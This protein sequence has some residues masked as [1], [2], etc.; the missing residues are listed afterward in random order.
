MKILL[1]YR[2]FPMALG[3]YFDW[4]LKDLGHQVFT[5]GCYNGGKIPWGPEFDFPDYDSPPDLEIPE[6]GSFP[7]E[8]V[9]NRMPWYP[10]M[11]LQAADTT[12]L[13]GKPLCPNVILATDPHSI[14]YLSR[15][16]DASHFACMQ[17]YYMDRYSFKNKFWVPYAYMPGIHKR[18]PR[19]EK[20]YD[21]VF[22]GLQ[23]EHRVQALKE[24]ERRGL[25]VFNTLGILFDEYNKTYNKGKIAFNWSSLE[26]LPAR[27][28]EGLAMGNCVL[29]NNQAELSSIEHIIP[30]DCYA[31]F[32]ENRGIYGGVA[33]KA[34]SLVST[35]IWKEIADRGWK[36]VTTGKNTYQDRCNLILEEVFK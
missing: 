34:V 15:L 28:W 32:N 35:D 11:V 18:I 8:T 23:Y 13:S 14:N 19:M 27:F 6:M 20:I 4:A 24:M 3:R 22:I 16:S 31:S 1:H 30:R 5:V 36:A 7:I 12:Y 29:T 10:E 33:D 21:V 9:I 17:K 26:D 25:K 2:H